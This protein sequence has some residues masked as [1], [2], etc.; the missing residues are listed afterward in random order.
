MLL[1]IVWPSS[2]TSGRGMLFNYGWITLIVMAVIVALGAIYE[3]VARPDKN[4]A[5]HRIE[6][7]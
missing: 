2:I 3:T 5:K 4:V 6:N 7:N 1:N